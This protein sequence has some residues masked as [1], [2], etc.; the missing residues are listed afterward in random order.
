MRLQSALVELPERRAKRR[1]LFRLLATAATVS[2]SACA[3][4]AAPEGVI[5]S[6]TAEAV[7]AFGSVGGLVV[8]SNEV[9]VTT[10]VVRTSA[11][12][13]IMQFAPEHPDAVPIAVFQTEFSTSG[14]SLGPYSLSPPPQSLSPDD[15]I[16][17]GQLLPLVQSGMLHQGEPVFVVVTDYDQNL[18]ALVAETVKVRIGTGDGEEVEWLRLLESGPSTGVFT[19]YIITVATEDRSGTPGDGV[20]ILG[21]GS[22]IYVEYVDAANPSDTVT[23]DR[24]VDS[25]GVVFDSST[26]LPIDGVSVTLIEVATNSPALVYGDDGV[27][28][29]PAT[30]TSGGVVTDSSGREYRFDPGRFRFPVIAPGTYRLV[31][32]APIGFAFPTILSEDILSAL[33]GGPYFVSDPGMRGEPFDLLAGAS[34]RIDLPL[35][36]TATSLFVSK[37]ASKDVVAVGDVL[38]YSLKVENATPAPKVAVEL[39]DFLPP[40]F[41]LLDGSV[42]ADS[43]SA[44][45]PAISADG[46]RLT[47]ALGDIVPGG[48]LRIRY[49]V[50]VG[51]GSVPGPAVNRARTRDATDSYSNEARAVV[52]VEPGFLTDAASIVGSVAVADSSGGSGSAPTGLG[53]VRIYLEDGTFVVTDER[54]RFHFEGVRPGTHVVQLDTESLPEGFEPSFG[55]ADRQV[56]RFVDLQGGTMWR[57]D[58]LVGETPPQMGSVSLELE[59]FREGEQTRFVVHL[60]GK[61]AAAKNVRLLFMLPD[62]VACETGSSVLD[63]EDLSDP[64]SGFGVNTYRLGEVAPDWTRRLSLRASGGAAADGGIP[65]PKVVLLFDAAGKTSRQTP[66]LEASSGQVHVDFEIERAGKPKTAA[67]DE[68]PAVMPGYGEVWLETAEPGLEWLWPPAGHLPSIPSLKLAIKHAPDQRIDL[69]LDGEPVNRVSLDGIL[70][71]KDG[72]VALS[73]WS[74]VDLHVGDNRLEVVVESEAGREV[75]RTLRI[76]HYSGPPVRAEIVEERCSLSADGRTPPVVAVRL[77]DEDGYPARRG[78]IGTFTVLPPH[79][80]LQDMEHLQNRPLTRGSAMDPQFVVGSDGITLVELQPTSRSGDAELSFHLASGEFELRPWLRPAAR[81]WILVGLAAGQAGYSTISEHMDASLRED[82]DEDLTL[83]GRVAFFTKGRIRGEWLLTMAFDSEQGGAGATDELFQTIDPDAYY[84][85]YGDATLQGHDAA[86]TSKLYLKLERNQF[87][88]LFG[89]FDTGLNVTDLSR[90]RRALSGFK[91]ELRSANYGL[92][93]F[94][95]RTDLA[96]RRDELRGNGTSGPYRLSR[97]DIL[98]NSE[99]VSIETRDRFHS[100][101]ILST[102]HLARHIDYDV[103]YGNGTLFFKEVVAGRDAALNPVTIVAE[104]ESRDD[105]DLATD[106]GGRGFLT[107][108]DQ[109]LVLGASR[110]REGAT[111]SEGDLWG[112]DAML[113]MGRG[114]ELKAEVATSEKRDADGRR[115]GS[116]TL[117]ELNRVGGRLEGSAHYRKQET[118]FGLGHQNRSESGLSKLGADFKYHPA[119]DFSIIGEA[120]RQTRLGDDATREVAEIGFDRSGGCLDLRGGFRQGGDEIPGGGTL[121][122]SQVLAGVTLRSFAERLRIRLDHERSLGDD[123]ANPAF[124]TRTRIGVEQQLHARATLFG[125]HEIARG[126]RD[127]TDGTRLGVRATPWQGSTL[128][129]SVG[130]RTG[131][132]GA[133][134]FANLGLVQKLWLSPRW[135]MDFGLDQSRTLRGGDASPFLAEAPVSM[136]ADEDYTAV[137]LSAAYRV[138]AWAWTARVEHRSADAADRWGLMAGALGEAR[139]GLALS[140]DLDFFRAEATGGANS[141][142]GRIRFGAA[143]RPAGGRW[144]LLDRLDLA[145]SS[146]AGGEFDTDEWRIVNNLNANYSPGG[147]WQISLQ[148]GTKLVRENVRGDGYGGFT[149]LYGMEA[150]YDL[151]RRWDAGLSG[152]V[153]HSWETGQIDL[154]TGASIGFKLSRSAWLSAGYNFR[155]FEDRDFADAGFTARGPFVQF[156]VKFDQ[157]SLRDLL[158]GFGGSHAHQAAAVRAATPPVAAPTPVVG[159]SVSSAR[160]AAIPMGSAPIVRTLPQVEYSPPIP[161]GDEVRVFFGGKRAAAPAAVESTSEKPAAAPTTDESDAGSE[162]NSAMAAETTNDSGESHRARASA[163]QATLAAAEER[164]ATGRMGLAMAALLLN[165]LATV[166]FGI[167]T[168]LRSGLARRGE[169][170]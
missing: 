45:R 37:T 130:R 129:S 17:L 75:S 138:D 46:R 40:G 6:N 55:D 101:R 72:S 48:S 100:E 76:V 34:F 57:T 148:T 15:P 162:G 66:L 118:G 3:S 95:S 73:L 159:A 134:L 58:F 43:S 29:L 94:V 127:D 10:V 113:R 49:V 133:R 170:L 65:V 18:D 116:A 99:Q 86:S 83:D 82:V 26:G 28:V 8:S 128:A 106:A 109:R 70:R 97:G 157:S 115:E 90:Y 20:V 135:S 31:V 142:D 4:L 87:Y 126:E 84:P 74:G 96:F 140:A 112:A 124:P 69:E 137:S 163:A 153:L 7:Y 78:T 23:T 123:N 131:E 11:T 144:T 68:R 111:G 120:W 121:R 132:S 22:R 150:R 119:P 35:D 89:D 108:L 165:V 44:T 169:R 77:L 85:L 13:E 36:P 27:S 145:A 158:G 88:A 56:S 143:Y 61:D 12:L 53:G 151:S 63:G 51:A 81:E 32:A 102:R 60:E 24:L 105:R 91:A 117:L 50:E 80:A 139:P 160:V 47:F 64:E 146:R 168:G 67:R 21:A 103:D 5:V 114:L 104:Y 59:S 149:D 79:A 71:S 41:R 161:M 107:L 156:R 93:V 141:S 16:V 2:L 122:S 92:N 52:R 136:A 19:G 152:S 125:E 25:S 1:N 42:R 33:P 164:A 39:E 166:G 14:Q 9:S 30:M 54:G 62:G 147:R 167:F 98:F 110:L 155:G 38:E 154:R